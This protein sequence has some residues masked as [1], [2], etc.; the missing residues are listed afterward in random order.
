VPLAG[1]E[2]ALPCGNLILRQ[3]VWRFARLGLLYKPAEKTIKVLV[4]PRFY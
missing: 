1:I 4:L 2:P 3:A